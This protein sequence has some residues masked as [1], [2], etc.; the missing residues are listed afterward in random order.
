MTPAQAIK[1]DVLR[2]FELTNSEAAAGADPLRAL[3]GPLAA[4]SEFIEVPRTVELVGPRLAYWWDAT[5]E[6]EPSKDLLLDFLALPDG[7]ASSVLAFAR[8]WGPLKWC[9]RHGAP[10]SHSSRCLAAHQTAS[11][12]RSWED[13]GVW[14]A[15]MGRMRGIFEALVMLK[16]KQVPQHLAP[17]FWE[18][19]KPDHLHKDGPVRGAA[20]SPGRVKN[21]YTWDGGY[22]YGF[23]MDQKATDAERLAVAWQTVAFVINGWLRAATVGPAIGIQASGEPRVFIGSQGLLGLEGIS[24]VGAL[25]VQMMMFAVS[26][27]EMAKCDACGAVFSPKRRRNPNRATYC[28]NCGRRAANVAARR[29]YRERMKT[30]SPTNATVGKEAG[31]GKTTRTR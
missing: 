9:E 21:P 24:L 27:R 28:S 31:S 26:G 7:D 15:W 20:D 16:N 1:R 11:K 3:A 23:R 5:V 6:R 17:W 2:K 8:R 12:Y 10:V 19:P 25:T 22:F 29:R 13:V 4:P 30:P 14:S 18:G